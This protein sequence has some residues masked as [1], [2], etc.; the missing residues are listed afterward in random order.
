MGQ[1]TSKI[2]QAISSKDDFVLSQL[3]SGKNVKIN[4]TKNTDGQTPLHLSVEV[5]APAC[6]RVLLENGAEV[7]LAGHQ[8]LSTS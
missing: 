8:Y 1:D 7:S 5:D 2:V 6:L 3:L 4:A